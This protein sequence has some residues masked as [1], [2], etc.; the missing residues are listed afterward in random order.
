[1]AVEF[2][3]D[4]EET[5]DAVLEIDADVV[6]GLLLLRLQLT[7]DGVTHGFAQVVAAVDGEIDETGRQ[8]V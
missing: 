1:M 4:L 8:T 2:Q 6:D 3:L 5:A 7:G